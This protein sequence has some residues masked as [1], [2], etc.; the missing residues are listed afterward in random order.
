MSKHWLIRRIERLKCRSTNIQPGQCNT[1]T[2]TETIKTTWFAMLSPHDSNDPCLIYPLGF[3]FASLKSKLF[4]SSVRVRWPCCIIILMA[5]SSVWCALERKSDR[6][7]SFISS[8]DVLFGIRL[9]RRKKS[10][11]NLSTSWRRINYARRNHERDMLIQCKPI[12]IITLTN[13]LKIQ[14][15]AHC[16]YFGTTIPCA[17]P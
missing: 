15:A 14:P 7:H 4:R 8:W 3:V 2:I 10:R 13:L 5:I 9:I 6:T 11:Y 1:I 12:S 17:L 16:T